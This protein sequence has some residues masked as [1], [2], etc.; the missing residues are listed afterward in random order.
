[1]YEIWC[2]VECSPEQT[3]TV[4]QAD[5]LVRALSFKPLYYTGATRRHMTYEE[6]ALYAT[7]QRK[8][9]AHDLFLMQQAEANGVLC[10]PPGAAPAA[11]APTAVETMA[12]EPVGFDLPDPEPCAI[13]MER[14]RDALLRPCGHAATCMQCAKNLLYKHCRDAPQC[15]VCRTPVEDLL[16][17]PKSVAAL[18]SMCNQ[19]ALASNS[20]ALAGVPLKHLATCAPPT[21]VLRAM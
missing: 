3:N 6:A 20:A 17:V 8:Q 21:H 9:C 16:P 1:M 7:R 2:R 4:I 13:C 15:V 5:K 18:R 11:I 12:T 10:Q 19:N 14:P